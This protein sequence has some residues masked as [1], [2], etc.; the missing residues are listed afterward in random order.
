MNQ[1]C[2]TMSQ[3]DSGDETM[4]PAENPIPAL[5]DLVE[6]WVP[7]LAE[8][9][10]VD[11][12]RIPEFVPPPLREVYRRTGNYPVP[13]TKQWRRPNWI[14]G[15]FGVQDQLLPIDQL[16][17]QGNRFRFIHE[18][19]GVWSCET[20]A[21]E[22]D[23][24]VYS[25]ATAYDH[26]DPEGTM[27]T[28]CSSLSHFLT[29]FCLQEIVFRSKH[30]LCVDSRADTPSDL[31]IQKVANVWVNGWYVYARPTHSFYLCEGSLFIMDTGG[32]YWLAY[33][34]SAAHSLI[35]P[36]AETRVIHSSPEDQ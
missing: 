25:D 22:S 1:V 36:K 13:F 32:D 17:V 5:L 19:Q 30:L 35:S 7:D 31:V 28:V 16:S 26:G 20:L 3:A 10:R 33:N 4:I 2:A 9:H 6:Q 21:D 14:P 23:P 11:A 12:G 24:P 27:R 8:E 18:N 34:D 15:L 29:T